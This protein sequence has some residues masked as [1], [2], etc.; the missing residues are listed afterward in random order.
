MAFTPYNPDAT[1]QESPVPAV[2]VA[3][4][5]NLLQSLGGAAK[6]VGNFLT[7]S[8]QGLGGDISTAI[9]ASKDI[10]QASDA[11]AHDQ[12]YLRTLITLKRNAAASGQP[13]QHYDTLINNFQP[14]QYTGPD[15]PTTGKVLADTAGTA[16]DLLSAGTYGAAKTGAMRSGE[17]AVKATPSVVSVAE[18]GADA[19][20]NKLAQV[21][22]KSAAATAAKDT[23]K[24]VDLVSP[25]LNA[26]QTAEALASRGGTKSGILGTLKVNVDPAAKRIADT[27]KQFV[28]DF[29]PSKSLTENINVTKKAV[30]TLANDLKQK[31]IETGQDRIYSFKEL[32]AQLRGVDK[33]AMLKA[34][35]LD[36]VFNSVTGKAME[37]A[38]NN[39]GKVSDLFQARKEFDDYVAK[40]FPNLY[41]SDTLTPMRIAIKGIRNAMTDFTAEHLPDIGLR[42]SLTAQSRLIDAVENMSQK[43]ASGA[44]KE[45]GTNVISRFAKNNP[46]KTQAVKY[47]AGIIGG[48]YLLDTARNAIQ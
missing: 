4:K 12:E 46:K 28:P 39:G 47:G 19:I 7:G 5:K 22:A 10:K 25:K 11:A 35:G 44:E 21:E 20:G 6:S 24:I 16:A 2:S 9:T 15:I 3:P 23:S 48:T 31:V 34:G 38:R 42:D 36:R 30:G 37:I 43:A 8:E 26:R 40:E 29:N 27:V 18:K 33:P 41:S 1:I 32:G 45:V 17:L 14:Q 13:T